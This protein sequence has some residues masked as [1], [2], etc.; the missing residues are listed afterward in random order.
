MKF[1]LGL[2]RDIFRLHACA[3]QNLR[4]SPLAIPESPVNQRGE[5]ILLRHGQGHGCGKGSGCGCV[6]DIQVAVD[7]GGVVTDA[8]FVAKRVVAGEGGKPILTSDG[9]LMLYECQCD[10]VKALGSIAT[11]SCKGHTLQALRNRMLFSPS[12]PPA[13]MRTL[14]RGLAPD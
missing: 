5:E 4:P 3:P 12:A 13:F 9:R 7:K 1:L 2:R 14:S 8:V 10:T 11:S 6:C